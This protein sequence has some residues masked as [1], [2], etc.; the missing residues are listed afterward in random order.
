MSWFRGTSYTFGARISSEGT[1]P[2]QCFPMK[3]FLP[4]S[5]I[6]KRKK[7]RKKENTV[8]RNKKSGKERLLE[9]NIGRKE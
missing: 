6:K 1:M 3:H 5:M 8:Y 4:N 9:S 2:P 7:E